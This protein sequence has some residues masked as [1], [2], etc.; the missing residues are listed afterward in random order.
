MRLGLFAGGRQCSP[1]A[2][3]LAFLFVVYRQIFLSIV[4][5]A[6]RMAVLLERGNAKGESRTPL[7]ALLGPV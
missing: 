6:L 7:Q 4:G 5:V 1:R 3:F 2:S